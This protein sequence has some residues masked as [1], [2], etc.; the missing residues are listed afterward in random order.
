M[1]RA[2]DNIDAGPAEGGDV[3]DDG[4]LL[5]SVIDTAPDAIVTIDTQG[6]VRSFSPAAEK[7][8]GFRADDV[9]GGNVSKLMPSPDKENH[10][11]YIA[12]YLRTGEKQI[13][14]IGR[15]IRARRKNGEVFSA[16]LAVGELVHGE[17]RLFTGFIRDVTDR[18]EAE[19]RADRL[20][21]ELAHLNRVQTMSE[22]ATALAHELNQPLTAISNYGQAARR[23]IDAPDTDPA[24]LSAMLDRIADQ[25]LRAGE[26][27]KRMRG[28]AQ[29]GEIERRPEDINVIV[30]EAVRLSLGSVMAR[31]VKVSFHL[32]DDLPSVAVD[33]IQ[34]QQVVVN[35]VRNA[36]DALMDGNR[37]TVDISTERVPPDDG[38]VHVVAVDHGQDA[39]RVSI[40]DNG[41]G[42]APEIADRLFD[43]LAT[44]KKT[45]LGVGLAI[46]RTIVEAHGGE[47]WAES[48]PAEGATFHFTLPVERDR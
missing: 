29:R 42:I 25:S 31:D 39:I 30:R 15:E 47:I 7:M 11:G 48:T 18:V 24:K 19:R 34:I 14:G 13:I 21:R 5:K 37:H 10:D 40:Q 17:H 33:R 45:G 38:Q 22:L 8:F 43:P 20:Q 44:T 9:V 4:S 2:E 12:R 3:F 35:L 41:P 46:C 28:F 32:A 6:I 27:M 1:T 36:I 23:L 26:I 16:E